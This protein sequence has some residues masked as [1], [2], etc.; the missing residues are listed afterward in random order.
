VA[1][2]DR[3]LALDQRGELFLI[4]AA[5]DEFVLLDRRE[6]AD[7]HTWAHLAVCGRELFVRELEALAV[8]EWG[9]VGED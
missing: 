4:R 6:I 2:R 9:D 3:I 8:Y 5:P 1:N 7:D